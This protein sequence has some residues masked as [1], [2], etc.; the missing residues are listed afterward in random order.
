LNWLA[1]HEITPAVA[2]LFYE[3]APQTPLMSASREAPSSAIEQVATMALLAGIEQVDKAARP[4][5]LS[6]PT[7]KPFVLLATAS[8]SFQCNPFCQR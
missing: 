5:Q 2:G 8:T 6:L 1:S 3:F 7:N 4:K